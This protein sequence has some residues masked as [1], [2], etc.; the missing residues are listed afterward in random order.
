MPPD[1]KH[2]DRLPGLPIWMDRLCLLIIALFFLGL[3]LYVALEW[4]FRRHQI[5]TTGRVIETRMANRPWESSC[6]PR[7]VRGFEISYF[8]ADK[9]GR[10]HTGS[11]NY[12]PWRGTTPAVGEE[13]PVLYDSAFP[14]RNR[15]DFR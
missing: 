2:C 8:F 5:S 1:K 4:H 3:V 13:V 15:I 6:N 11:C 7:V 10:S 14:E 12:A 9:F